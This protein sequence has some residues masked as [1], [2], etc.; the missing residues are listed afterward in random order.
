MMLTSKKIRVLECIRQGKIGGGESHL[1]NL[2][3]YLDRERFEPL[4]LSF[5]DGPMIDRLKQMDVETDVIY[6][7]RP[8]DITKWRKVKEW[9]KEHRIDLIHAHGT[10]ASSNVTWGAPSLGIPVVNTIQGWS[11]HQDQHALL[12]RMRIAGEKYITSRT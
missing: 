3:E 4:V 10:R 9:L 5:T 6:T 12:R 1:L 7:E 8:F 11:F 2:G